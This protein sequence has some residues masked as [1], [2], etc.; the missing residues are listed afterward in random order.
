MQINQAGI[1]PLLLERETSRAEQILQHAQPIHYLS[2]KL[3]K[4]IL[5]WEQLLN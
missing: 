2:L 4:I 3:A 1:F 5:D